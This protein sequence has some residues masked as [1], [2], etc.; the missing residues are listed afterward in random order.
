MTNQ[1][2]INGL[3]EKNRLLTAKNDEYVSLA[4]T[5]AEKERDYLKALSIKTLSLRSEGTSVTILKDIANGIHF[6][7]LRFEADVAEAICKACLNSIKILTSQIDT[8]RSLLSWLK[9]EMGRT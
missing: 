5:C 6:A 3:A 4:K 1:E 2:I 7:D 8:Y 9:A